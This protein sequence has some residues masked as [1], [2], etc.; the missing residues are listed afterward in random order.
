MNKHVLANIHEQKRKERVVYE[1]V[2]L[3]GHHGHHVGRMVVMMIL[4][5]VHALLRQ[6]H[7]ILL[8]LQQLLLLGSLLPQAGPEAYPRRFLDLRRLVELNC[9]RRRRI[10]HIMIDIDRLHLLTGPVLARRHH[11]VVAGGVGRLLIG[12]RRRRLVTIHHQRVEVDGVGAQRPLV[13]QVLQRELVSVHLL[14][15]PHELL[16]FAA[17]LAI[18][19]V[20]VEEVGDVERVEEDIHAGEA[21]QGVGVY[22]GG[23]GTGR[24]GDDIGADDG[25]PGAQRHEKDE[26]AD[27]VLVQR[28]QIGHGGQLLRDDPSKVD[29]R[30]NEQTRGLDAKVRRQVREREGHEAE[31]AYEKY[32][33]VGVVEEV[34]GSARDRRREGDARPV[35]VVPHVVNDLLREVDVAVQVPLLLLLKVVGVYGRLVEGRLSKVDLVLVPVRGHRDAQVL[36]VFYK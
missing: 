27:R 23:R 29:R 20:L 35:V 10:V 15:L 13:F 7:V 30:E 1:H 19:H 12:R 14:L 5:V 26:R 25:V 8:A 6:H 21:A 22:G 18:L 17:D 28:G 11:G 4:I 9:R 31:H 24:R 36:N 2:S 3:N 16:G 32:E 34:A 33:H